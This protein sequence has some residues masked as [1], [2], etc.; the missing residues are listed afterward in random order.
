VEVRERGNNLMLTDWIGEVQLNVREFQDGQIHE[1]W[2]QLGRGAWKVH[3]RNPRGAIHLSAQLMKNKYDRPF[4]GFEVAKAISF[5]EW[6]KNVP[7]YTPR[8]E[9]QNMRN[10]NANTERLQPRIAPHLRKKNINETS[11]E[12]SKNAWDVIAANRQSIT[13]ENIFN[14]ERLNRVNCLHKG[15]FNE[16]E[17]KKYMVCVDGTDSSLQ[18]FS[19]IV[20]LMNPKLDHLFIVCVRE[21]FIMDVPLYER[22]LAFLSHELWKAASL[23][24]YSLMDQ[25]EGTGIDY[26]AMI[27]HAEDS[28]ATVC[29]LVK[30]YNVDVLVVGKHTKSEKQHHSRYFRSFRKYCQAHV[31]CSFVCIGSC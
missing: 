22:S 4:E 19:N 17:G 10:T 15:N 26:T 12:I 9:N 3:R 6:K 1:K 20:K 28:R 27:P 21:S 23:I 18:A 31:K 13:D 7:N 11:V 29:T 25:L 16:C 30:R 2:C 14:M 5:E 24:I 8:E